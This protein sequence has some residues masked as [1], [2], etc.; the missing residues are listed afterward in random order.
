MK[1]SFHKGGRGRTIIS[2]GSDEDEQ[3]Q[4]I[5]LLATHDQKHPVF[6]YRIREYKIILF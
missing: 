4:P 2:S 6:S 5:R 1:K 3:M